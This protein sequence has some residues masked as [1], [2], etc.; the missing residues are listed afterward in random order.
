MDEILSR[1]RP[2]WKPQAIQGKCFTNQLMGCF[3]GSLQEL[4]AM[5]LLVYGRLTELYVDRERETWRCSRY[6][7]LT[8]AAPQIY[9]SFQNGICYE[10]VRE[11]VLDDAQLIQPAMYLLIAIENGKIL[12][13]EFESDNPAEN[14][15]WKKMAQFLKLVQHAQSRT[16][17]S[18]S[19][20]LL[21][22]F[23]SI[24]TLSDER[25]TLKRHLSPIRSPTVLCHNDLLTKNIIYD[26]KE[27]PQGVKGIDYSLLTAYLERYKHSVGLGATITGQ[28]VQELYVQ[29]CKFSLVS[30]IFWDLWAIL[31]ARHSSIDFNFER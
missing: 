10:F 26:H 6:S 18:Q 25:E 9:C 17:A 29:V 1:L 24:E 22:E 14:I 5:Q 21:K 19:S 23:P 3:V 15:L 28:E 30:N 20:K 2:Q 27:G 31:Q 12:S 13:I 7:T 11:T 8:T 4:G 16:P